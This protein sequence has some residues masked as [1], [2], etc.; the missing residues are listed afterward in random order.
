VIA[1]WCTCQHQGQPSPFAGFP[2]APVTGERRTHQQRLIYPARRLG[3]VRRAWRSEALMARAR[4]GISGRVTRRARVQRLIHT[5]W[6]ATAIRATTGPDRHTVLRSA[7]QHILRAGRSWVGIAP[8]LGNHDGDELARVGSSIVRSNNTTPWPRRKSEPATVGSKPR[9]QRMSVASDPGIVR[10]Q[11]R[12]WNGKAD[13]VRS[14]TSSHF[15]GTQSGDRPVRQNPASTSRADAPHDPLPLSF[16][17]RES[18]V[19]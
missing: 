5:G 1:G 16:A 2:H 12:R 13:N 19:R 14:F 4:R 10:G 11:G 7:G 9:E 15:D 18:L 3:A 6:A 8:L 17:S